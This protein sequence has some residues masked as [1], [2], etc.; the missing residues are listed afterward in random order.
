M[1]SQ[2]GKIQTKYLL[3][4]PLLNR[5]CSDDLL[6]KRPRGGARDARRASSIYKWAQER[7]IYTTVFPHLL[8]GF[9]SKTQVLYIF[10]ILRPSGLTWQSRFSRFP[11][12][13]R[14]ISGFLLWAP[15][16]HA[17]TPSDMMWNCRISL[18]ACIFRILSRWRECRHDKS[19]KISPYHEGTHTGGRHSSAPNVTVGSLHKMT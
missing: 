19:Y 6:L 17:L 3:G 10:R 8:P 18:C 7:G 14:I 4:E 15:S 13:I 11:C 2:R 1:T 5:P 12:Q 9:W 16:S